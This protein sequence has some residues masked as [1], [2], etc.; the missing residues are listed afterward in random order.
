[1][2]NSFQ[3]PRAIR[4]ATAYSTE[5]T[6]LVVLVSQLML[7]VLKMLKPYSSKIDRPSINLM[8]A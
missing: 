1:M 3:K 5:V 2:P 8:S 7:F 4:T 6:H